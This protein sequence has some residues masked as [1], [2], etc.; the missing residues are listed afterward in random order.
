MYSIYTILHSFFNI[1][2]L[3]GDATFF[4]NQKKKN[5]LKNLPISGR[6]EGTLTSPKPD[7]N[8]LI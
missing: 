6:G 3:W 2:F 7:T 1:F 5:D 4:L 8:V